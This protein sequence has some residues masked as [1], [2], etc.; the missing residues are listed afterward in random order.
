[1]MRRKTRNKLNKEIRDAQKLVIGEK[2]PLSSKE[3]MKS[4]IHPA[5]PREMYFGGVLEADACID[6]FL[7][8]GYTQ[9]LNGM[10]DAAS[11]KIIALY[12]S[13]QETTEAYFQVLRKTIENP[14]FG[15][16]KLIKTDCR[17]TF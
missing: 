5:K 10:I 13:E 15:I 14:E 8:L 9:A 1:M 3:R 4:D 7:G 12:L 11:S 6:D 17:R 2:I 16:P